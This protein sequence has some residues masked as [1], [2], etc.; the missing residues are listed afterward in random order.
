MADRS[1]LLRAAASRRARQCPAPIIQPMP[2]PDRQPGLIVGLAPA[3][4]A[5][6]CRQDLGLAACSQR[7]RENVLRRQYPDLADKLGAGA[8]PEA[9]GEGPAPEAV[10]TEK[11]FTPLPVTS[12]AFVSPCQ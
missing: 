11:P 4:S 2:G 10:A 1:P 7:F 12:P 5:L 9:L 8:A 3:N 6:E